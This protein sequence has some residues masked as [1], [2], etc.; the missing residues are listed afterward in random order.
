M[1]LDTHAFLLKSGIIII[2]MPDFSKK[3]VV[4]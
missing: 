1:E 2:I 4:L 3:V